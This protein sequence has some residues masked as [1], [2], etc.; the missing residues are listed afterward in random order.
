MSHIGKNS[1]PTKLKKKKL[2]SAKPD[3]DL[4]RP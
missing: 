4:D 2:R 1:R 3:L